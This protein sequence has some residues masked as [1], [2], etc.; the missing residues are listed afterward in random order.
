MQYCLGRKKSKRFSS[1]SDFTDQIFTGEI[2][3]VD[4]AGLLRQGLYG[5]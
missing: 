4:S 1:A 2:S 3:R 5:V